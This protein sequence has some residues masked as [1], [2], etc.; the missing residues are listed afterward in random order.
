[1]I[2]ETIRMTMAIRKTLNTRL[3]KILEV[4]KDLMK[5]LRLGV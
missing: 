4:P 1:M 5:K 2:R 3:D